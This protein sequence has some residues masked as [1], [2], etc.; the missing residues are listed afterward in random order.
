VVCNDRIILVADRSDRTGWTTG[1]H[2]EYAGF[3][4]WVHFISE[5]PE[6]LPWD[7]KKAGINA[8]SDAYRETVGWLKGIADEFRAQKN[9]LRDR[10]GRQ[11]TGARA[12][13]GSTGTSQHG[14]PSAPAV[15]PGARAGPPPPSPPSL[16]HT[17]THAT[18]FHACE[19][20]TTSP[21]VRSLAD[22]AARL[23]IA[24]FPYAG[25]LLLRAFFEIVLVDYLK[26]KGRYGDVKQ[27]VFDSQAAQGRPFTLA[28]Q[29][30][31][32]PTLDH[33]LEWLVKNEDAFPDHELR[34]CR[35]ACENFKA[36]VKR[37]NGIVHEDGVLTGSSQVTSFRNDVLPTLR[38]LL[39][40]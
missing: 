28:Q 35:R 39:E 36:H 8:S 26:R 20:K 15:P 19:I 17:E 23:E 13:L 10:P 14:P 40:S 16:K 3:L 21:K 5:D 33:V 1:W 22:E 37:I 11:R 6:L 7:S 9:R 27:A 30:N 29:R 2:N 32:S 12:G 18:L 34:T 24:A 38:I 31:F 25:A 4:G